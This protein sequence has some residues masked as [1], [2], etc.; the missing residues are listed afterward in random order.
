LREQ[1]GEL[2]VLEL[3][4]KVGDFHASEAPYIIL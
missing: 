3:R 1:V 2:P 4:L